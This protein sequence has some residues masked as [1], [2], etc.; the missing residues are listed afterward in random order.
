[1]ENGSIQLTEAMN[2][3]RKFID[4][5]PGFLKERPSP[6]SYPAT[7]PLFLSPQLLATTSIPPYLF[8]PIVSPLFSTVPPASF[9]LIDT[10]SKSIWLRLL[11]LAPVCYSL[12]PLH[13]KITTGHSR[14]KKTPIDPPT[15]Q[16]SQNLGTS[17]GCFYF[18]LLGSAMLSSAPPLS[19]SALL[20]GSPTRSPTRSP[21][22]ADGFG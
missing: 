18:T 10:L 9:V 22:F 12:Q 20:V 15:G 14:K 13:D 21:I 3:I 16:L 5:R 7:S 1:M 11:L 8:Q 6:L 17:P 19:Y 2:K 4:E